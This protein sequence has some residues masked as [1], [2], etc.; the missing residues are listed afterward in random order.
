MPQNQSI[1]IRP[2]FDGQT[3]TAQHNAVNMPY[4]V[5]RCAGQWRTRDS[6]IQMHACIAIKQGGQSFVNHLHP[7][8]RHA[9]GTRHGIRRP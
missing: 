8:L 4:D 1:G 7:Q 2:A 3:L 9:F 6:Q 5:T